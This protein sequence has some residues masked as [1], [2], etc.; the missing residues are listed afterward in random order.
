M[1]EN[2]VIAFLSGM[3]ICFV[4]LVWVVPLGGRIAKKTKKKKENNG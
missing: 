2:I 1:I 3:L 4:S